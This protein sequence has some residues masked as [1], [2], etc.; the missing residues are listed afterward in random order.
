MKKCFLKKFLHK[1]FQGGP[2][3][4]LYKYNIFNIKLYTCLKPTILTKLRLLVDRC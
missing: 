1:T 4:I 2:L 3:T